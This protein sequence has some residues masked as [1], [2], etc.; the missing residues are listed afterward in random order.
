MN[1]T[2]LPAVA[3]PVERVVVLQPNGLDVRAVDPRN[4][5]KY[6]PNLHRWLTMRNK[7]H[8]AW[9][10]RVYRNDAGVL[11]IGMLDNGDIFG[12]RLMNVLCYGTKAESACWVGMR[13]LVEVTDF[14]PR[15]VTDGRCAID[16]EHRN[17]FVG[18]DTR[19]TQNGDMRACL[20]C[21]KGQQVL[22]RWT[23]IVARQEWQDLQH[24]V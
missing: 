24:N 21:G 4:G 2:E 14:W 7:K 3:G 23:E 8:H 18:D 5:A 19:W 11:W 6:S 15:Y 13:G 16:T 12:A 9:T 20:W 17:S 22:A 10:A 1:A